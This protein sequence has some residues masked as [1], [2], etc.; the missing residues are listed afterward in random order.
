MILG[1]AIAGIVA[2]LLGVGFVVTGITNWE[3]FFV[4]AKGL[5]LASLFGRSGAR[6]AW[7]VVG[8][9]L[10]WGGLAV[11]AGASLGGLIKAAQAKAREIKAR[12]DERRHIE[13]FE[14]PVAARPRTPS[15]LPTPAE[16][17][18]DPI[19]RALARAKS[20]DANERRRG[21]RDLER[22]ERVAARRAE[23]VAALGRLIEDREPRVR[24]AALRA[25]VAWEGQNAVVPLIRAIDDQGDEVWKTAVD[26]LA[27]LGDGRAAGAVARRLP[28]DRG[29]VGRALRSFGNDAERP[30]LDYLTHDNRDVRREAIRVLGDVGGQASYAAIEPLT[31]DDDFFLRSD[32]KRAVEAILRRHPEIAPVEPP[33]PKPRTSV[34]VPPRPMPPK[35][36]PPKPVDPLIQALA[37]LKGGDR[38]RVRRALGELRRAEPDP[39]RRQEIAEAI[40]G[41]LGAEDAGVRAEAVKALAKW[42]TKDTMP[43]LFKCLDDPEFPV[44]WAAFDALGTLRDPRAVQAVCKA[45][46]GKERGRAAR[47]LKAMGPFAEGEVLKAT[48]HPTRE[49][50]LE[51]IKV[52]GDIGTAKSLDTL[53]RLLQDENFFVRTAAKRSGQAIVAREKGGGK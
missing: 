19:T 23:V 14:Q 3:W 38:H 7:G 40:V 51:A 26:L 37:D 2:F 43:E 42:H 8:V 12:N 34:A 13:M 47:A 10:I 36:E 49:V 11:T 46:A 5:L 41:Y 31:R 35:P 30:V 28:D 24:S 48:A 27:K 50:R 18:P 39:Q 4:K 21:A 32:A 17:P 45:L 25:L 9:V 33:K 44:R 1:V 22:I 29:H 6:I 52:L 20:A 53:R 15:L 16:P